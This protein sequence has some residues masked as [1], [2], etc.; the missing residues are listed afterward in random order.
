[1]LLPF[2]SFSRLAVFFIFSQTS[3]TSSLRRQTHLI[4]CNAERNVSFQQM[5]RGVTQP[6]AS[7]A[8]VRRITRSSRVPSCTS[9]A[10]ATSSSSSSSSQKSSYESSHWNERY[11]K[12]SHEWMWTFTDEENDEI[13]LALRHFRA[14]N[15]DVMDVTAETFP[16]SSSFQNKLLA[17]RDEILQGRGFA[18]QRGLTVAR[19]SNKDICTIFCAIGKIMGIPVSQNKFGHVLGHVYD[20]GNDPLSPSTRLY[21]TSAAQPFHTDSADIV[22]LLCI[23]NASAGGD[24]Q[25]VSSVRCYEEIKRERADLAEVLLQPFFVSRKGEIPPGCGPTYEM[26]VFHEVEDDRTGEKN[27]IGIYDRSFIDAAQT[28]EGTPKLTSLQI[29]AL[30]YLDALCVKR[31]IEMRLQS[32]DIQ[33]LHNHTT[34]HARSAFKNESEFPRH[35]LRLWLSPENGIKLPDAFKTRFNSTERGSPN[36][37]GIKI[38][39]DVKLVCPLE[40]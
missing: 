13:E 21:T 24:S 32:G 23:R 33:W 37:G 6:L 12:E 25:W 31:Q 26:A 7:I 2:F 5:S 22:G 38:K 19:Y 9:N 14:T 28:I 8:E 10:A 17:M 30:N 16:L 40:P 1:M 39:D 4:I 27:I 34:F 11:E 3:E 20:L 29:E 15:L 35:L 18:V 36:R